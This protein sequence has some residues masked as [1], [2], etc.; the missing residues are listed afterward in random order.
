MKKKKNQKPKLKLIW[1]SAKN[2]NQLE[3]PLFKD[4]PYQGVSGVESRFSTPWT[5]HIQ[6][7][8]KKHV[9]FYQT[10]KHFIFFKKCG[11]IWS[12]YLDI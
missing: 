1:D 8:K 11:P 5:V 9:L 12:I 6:N 10:I 2:T 3:K 4:H 7:L